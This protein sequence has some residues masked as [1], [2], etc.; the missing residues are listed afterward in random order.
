MIC[1]PD[2]GIVFMSFRIHTSGVNPR[3]GLLAG[4]V[5]S[6]TAALALGIAPAGWLAD[7]LDLAAEDAAAFLMRRYAASATAA[8]FVATIGLVRG[9]SPQRAGL[10]ALSTWF[11]VQ[12]LVA[13][14]GVISGTVG[15]LAW[16]VVFVDPL[17]AAWSF[18]LSRKVQQ[19]PARVR[20]PVRH[21]T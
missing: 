8:L 11:A 6:G 14:V 4:A 7:L 12:G 16:L 5:V 21:D 9:I 3:Y 19:G 1:L 10:L 20:A 13:I 17:L 15:S 18:V 2:K